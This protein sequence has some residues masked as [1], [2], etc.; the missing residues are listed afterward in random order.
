MYIFQCVSVEYFHWSSVSLTVSPYSRHQELPENEMFWPP[1]TIRLV[2]CRKFGREV[3]VGTCTI[4]NLQ[5][6]IWVPPEERQRML[7]EQRRK[8]LAI[9]PAA[10]QMH[11]QLLEQ[12]Q[13]LSPYIPLQSLLEEQRKEAEEKALGDNISRNGSAVRGP[14][15]YEAIND[16][17]ISLA[18]SG[19]LDSVPGHTPRGS[20]TP[21]MVG[22]RSPSLHSRMEVT[23]NVSYPR[24]RTGKSNGCK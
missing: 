21:S 13:K 2:D 4:T 8:K 19:A 24:L 15:V 22:S 18:G 17:H 14:G 9:L 1:A 12:Q 6:N 10:R 23:S 16:S 3:L 5:N 20:V 7:E 11:E